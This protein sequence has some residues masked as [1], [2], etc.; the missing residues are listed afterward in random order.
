[1]SDCD[2]HWLR[3]RADQ[4]RS[5]ISDL[6]SEIDRLREENERLREDAERYRAIQAQS[7]SDGSRGQRDAWAD[8]LRRAEAAEA[9]VAD[10][11]LQ[12]QCTFSYLGRLRH[13]GRPSPTE[14]LAYWN[15]L[16]SSLEEK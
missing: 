2:H 11:R 6:H 15:A 5:E 4:L 13:G 7:F 14:L 9:K 12:L 1:M 8:L 10:L 16:R 3:E